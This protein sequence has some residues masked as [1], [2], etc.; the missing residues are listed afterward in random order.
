MSV[1]ELTF[2]LYPARLAALGDRRT[3]RDGQRILVQPT[4]A[5]RQY[6]FTLV[7]SWA[8]IARAVRVKARSDVLQ[9]CFD[10]TPGRVAVFTS[11]TIELSNKAAPSR[12]SS[13]ER[14]AATRMSSRNVLAISHTCSATRST[15][16]LQGQD[17]KTSRSFKQRRSYRLPEIDT[18]STKSQSQGR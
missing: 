15:C 1:T 12:S 14:R 6:P 8:Y 4:P 18:L 10:I 9:A 17:L 2:I 16:S 11:C 5:E 13:A 3:T 7:L